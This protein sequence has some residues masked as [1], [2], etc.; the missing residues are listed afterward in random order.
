[1]GWRFF[2]RDGELEHLVESDSNYFV[3][4]PRRVGKTSLL[5]ETKRLLESKGVRVFLIAC[6][7][8]DEPSQVV[9]EILRTL[10]AR[11]VVTAKRRAHLLDESMLPS[12]LKT[13]TRKH[14]KVVL[15]LDELGNAIRK[16]DRDPWLFMGALREYSQSGNLRIIMSG[17]QQIYRK[18]GEF[19]SPFVNFAA[20]LPL[21]GFKDK[22]IREC[23]IDPLSLWGTIR[24]REALRQRVTSSIGRQPFLLQYFGAALFARILEDG[25]E[26]IDTLAERLLEEDALDVFLDAVEEIF[27][28]FMPS[29]L[30][31]YLF[32]RCCREAELVGTPLHSTEITDT[33]IRDA[34]SDLGYPSTHDQR[35]E[36]LEALELRGLTAPIGHQMRRH[37]IAAPIVY[38]C[39][40]ESNEPI[41]ELIDI[42]AEEIALLMDT[43]Q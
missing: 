24:D 5:Q 8:K 1:V 37:H 33:W 2:G 13:V 10:D 17:W 30:Q 14:R 18:Q 4:G 43:P 15:I 12:V 35:R 23:L 11:S 9:E 42:L 20:V 7:D 22:E 28:R 41:D 32:L 3:V 25:S 16:R 36:V 40:K 38:R 31:R 34:L 21:R 29:P 26:D 39:V 6:Q 19:D 27:F